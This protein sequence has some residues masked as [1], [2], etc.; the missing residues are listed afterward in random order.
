MLPTAAP[1]PAGRNV[2]ILVG[3]ACAGL[4]LAAGRA[5]RAAGKPVK[6]VVAMGVAS[7]RFNALMTVLGVAHH[8]GQVRCAMCGGEG[9]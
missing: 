3:A 5:A 4:A 8:T 6:G 9:T 2:S 7:L 1:R